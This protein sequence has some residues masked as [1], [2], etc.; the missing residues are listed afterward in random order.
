[1]LPLEKIGWENQKESYTNSLRGRCVLKISP[2]LFR[3]MPW[4]LRAKLIK[5]NEKS[6]GMEEI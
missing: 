2:E 1:M 5:S 4:H 6:I 3:I